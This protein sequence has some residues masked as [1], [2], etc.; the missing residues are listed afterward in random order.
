MPEIEKEWDPLLQ[1]LEDELLVVD[2]ALSPD[3]KLVASSSVRLWDTATG[4]LLKKF[5]PPGL[6]GGRVAFSSNGKL[7]MSLSHGGSLRVWDIASGQLVRELKSSDD[8]FYS[9]LETSS[10]GGTDLDPVSGLITIESGQLDTTSSDRTDSDSVSGEIAIESGLLDTS[11]SDGTDSDSVSDK[12]ATMSGLNTFS[13]DGTVAVYVSDKATIEV[14]D[15]MNGEILVEFEA[16]SETLLS[17]A[18]SHDT[19]L[20]ASAGEDGTVRLWDVRTGILRNQLKSDSGSIPRVAI[21][22]DGRMVAT[23]WSDGTAK[24]WDADTAELM[25]DIP[26]YFHDVVF[27]PDG[28][29]LATVEDSEVQLWDLS[30]GCDSLRAIIRIN[31]RCIGL[32]FS[33]DGRYFTSARLYTGDSECH[34][35]D[36]TIEIWDTTNGNLVKVLNGHSDSVSEVSFSMRND[37]LASVSDDRTVRL[38]DLTTNSQSGESQRERRAVRSIEFSPNRKIAASVSDE[39]C[40]WNVETGALR[41]VLDK[42]RSVFDSRFSPDGGL[43]VAAILQK[44]NIWDT[45]TGQLVRT[46]KHYSQS[47]GRFVISSDGSFIAYGFRNKVWHSVSGLTFPEEGKDLERPNAHDSQLFGWTKDGLNGTEG[48]KVGIWDMATG[49]LL[50]IIR[51]NCETV[52]SLDFSLDG[53]MLAFTPYSAKLA[54][55]ERSRIEIWDMTKYELLTILRGTKGTI[56]H[57]TWSPDGKTIASTS[58]DGEIGL[59]DVTTGM[60]TRCLYDWLAQYTTFSPD[61]KLLISAS[62]NYFLQIWELSTGTVI[63]THRTCSFPE[64]LRFS[65]DGNAIDTHMGR[66][67]IRSI[68]PGWK[69]TTS[70]DFYVDGNLIIHGTKPALVLPHDYQASSA[71]AVDNTLVIGHKSGRVTFLELKAADGEE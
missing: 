57:V 23:V 8:Q 58:A 54:E 71:A 16:H 21:S 35:A 48:P 46:I 18:L 20:L 32:R 24:I 27:S 14:L 36:K 29:V 59:W 44:I 3:G 67:D 19:K 9:Q 65:Q 31:T 25:G 40:L 10:S 12:K 28:K 68:Y 6:G 34:E 53:K 45:S 64:Y 52:D 42:G 66:V 4:T 62:A 15:V 49:A 55:P 33:P 7:L 38:W 51:G 56:Q 11:S 41:H 1:T 30:S 2:V 13:S 22:R 69:S 50:Q 60:M 63:G 61:G 70:R 37:I 43:F 47:P 39:I 17:L 26:G 5:H